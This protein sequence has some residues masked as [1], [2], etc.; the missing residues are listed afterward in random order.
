MTTPRIYRCPVCNGTG[1]PVCMCDGRT[2]LVD[3]K[4][5]LRY[6]RTAKLPRPEPLPPPP[7]RMDRPCH[8]CA[9]RKGSPEREDAHGT[10]ATLSEQIAHGVPF[11][12]HQGMHDASGR[13][14]PIYG[15]DA[16]RQPIGYPI[17]A[18]WRAM[19]DAFERGESAVSIARR[20]AK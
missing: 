13:Y 4:T 5:A 16:N 9:F 7:A 8:D 6:A 20:M 1:E 3:E 12:C 19:R 14:V 17:C 10:I 2:G 11:F 18:G 15:F